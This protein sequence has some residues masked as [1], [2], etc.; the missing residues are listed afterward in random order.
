MKRGRRFF[1]YKD[2]IKIDGRSKLIDTY[3]V[4]SVEIHDSQGIEGLLRE[5][6]KGEGNYFTNNRAKV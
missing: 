5:E 2:H 1:G 4:T 6:D 3:E